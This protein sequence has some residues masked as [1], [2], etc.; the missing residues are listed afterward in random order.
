MR[1]WL[2]RSADACGRLGLVGDRLQAAAQH[3]HRAGLVLQLRALVLAGHDHAGGQ[4]GDPDRGV[5]GV[6]ALPALARRPED[7]D[8]QVLLVDLDVRGGVH[9][10]V[11]EHAGRG[12]VDAALRLGDRDALHAVHAALVLQPGPDALGLV[13]GR[14]D[15][16]GDVLVAA[17]VGL[18]RREHLDLPAPALGVAGVHAQQ[19]AGEQRRL[20]AALPGLHLDHHV[21]R[22]RGVAGHELL[23][24]AVAQRPDLRLELRGL[25]GE[26]GVLPGELAGVG[27]VG[28]G[29]AQLLDGGD[30]RGERG[31]A[32]AQGAGERLVGVHVGVGEARLEPRVLLEQGRD[33]GRRRHRVRRCLRCHRAPPLVV[34]L[35][36]TRRT[37]AAPRAWRRGDGRRGSYF[38]VGVRLP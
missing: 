36:R 9:L 17:E 5:G 4:V 3:V 33:A 2:R 1:T 20:L 35:P 38:L 18:R 14:G 30:H 37:P 22:V 31:V 15:G 7:V 6:D 25:G 26:R 13:A 8:A 16:D 24:Q 28:L 23:G 32:P 10:G 11:D 19:V 34:N 27:E 12:G 21:V 29:P